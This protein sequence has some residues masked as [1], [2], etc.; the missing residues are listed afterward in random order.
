MLHFGHYHAMIVQTSKHAKTAERNS[1]ICECIF[2]QVAV[3][4]VNVNVKTIYFQHNSIFLRQ[5][6]IIVFII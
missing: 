1:T 5:K 4:N 6:N 2:H 3:K